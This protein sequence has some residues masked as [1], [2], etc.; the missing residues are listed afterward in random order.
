MSLLSPKN[1]RPILIVQTSPM[2]TGSTVLVNVLYGLVHSL[3]NQPI[4]NFWNK[5]KPCT[6]V[7]KVNIIKTHILDLE[8]FTETYGDACDIYFVCSERPD[9]NIVIQEPYRSYPNLVIIDYSD[10][11]ETTT[12]TV[13]NIVNTVYKKILTILPKDKDV[14]FSTLTAK[15]RLKEMN[16]Y[17]ETI[18]SRPFT[19]VNA[20]YEI[21]GSHRIRD[22]SGNNLGSTNH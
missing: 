17:Y 1:Y 14:V 12:N 16:Q 9:Q 15:K 8:Y 11:L 7:N 3:S 13:D 2:R 5:N 18:K 4:L 10:L 20:F 19:Y 21:H 22:G 6:F